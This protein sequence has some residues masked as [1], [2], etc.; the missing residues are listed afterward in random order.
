MKNIFRFLIAVLPCFIFQ[1]GRC[2]AEDSEKSASYEFQKGLAALQERNFE[3]AKKWFL[4]S[5]NKGNADAQY[6]TGYMDSKGWTG[7][8]D[9]DQ[10]FLWFKKSAKAGKKEAQYQTACCYFDGKGTKKD[11]ILGMEWLEKAV[12]Q[13]EADAEC[14]LGIC[15]GKGEGVPVNQ[16][17]AIKCF[18]SALE[19]GCKL[20]PKDPALWGLEGAS[21]TVSGYLK[22]NID[23]AS[24]KITGWVLFLEKPIS[25]GK[26]KNIPAVHVEPTLVTD[27]MSQQRVQVKGVYHWLNNPQQG[28]ELEIIPVKIEV[29]DQ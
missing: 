16:K 13:G 9:W 7:K 5:A 6:F 12:N 17:M 2:L 3:E 8:V 1:T 24:G 26:K 21:I 4:Y 15:Y 10:A 18:K 14:R 28:F 11:P 22:S 20:I 29:Q 25:L 27:E 19:H 23:K